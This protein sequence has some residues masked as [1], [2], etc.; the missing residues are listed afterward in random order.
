MCARGPYEGHVTGEV[1]EYQG[2]TV[3]ST[4]PKGRLDSLGLGLPKIAFRSHDRRC[5]LGLTDVLV[6]HLVSWEDREA[7]SDLALQAYL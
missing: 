4:S 5:Y 7:G 2:Q 3:K 1:E 6:V